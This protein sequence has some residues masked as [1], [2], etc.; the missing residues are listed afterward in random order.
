MSKFLKIYI[1]ILCAVFL[2]IITV[3]AYSRDNYTIE[4][5]DT[6]TENPENVFAKKNG[7]NFNIQITKN[8][9]GKFYYNDDFLNEITDSFVNDMDLYIDKIKEGVKEQYKGILTEEQIED[10]I[11]TIKLNGLVS[12]EVTTFTKNNYPAFHYVMNYTFGEANYNVE[13]YQLASE[14]KIYTVT[15]TGI[16]DTYRNSDEVKKILDS[17]TITNYVDVA[18]TENQYNV[19]KLIDYLKTSW[20]ISITIGVLVVASAT[21]VSIYLKKQQKIKKV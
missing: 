19:D 18:L 15:I 12:K 7:N 14:N 2:P 11:S 4:V 5:P 10:Y 21:A 13:L 1:T 17:F 8:E 9:S 16:D 6:Y 20:G 3:N